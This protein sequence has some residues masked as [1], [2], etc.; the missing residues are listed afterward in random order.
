MTGFIGALSH[1]TIR[2]N[3]RNMNGEIKHEVY[4]ERQNEIFFLTKH[5]ET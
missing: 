1:L 3:A 2:R 5:G 4:D